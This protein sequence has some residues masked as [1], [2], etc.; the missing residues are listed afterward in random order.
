MSYVT[1]CLLPRR[2]TEATPLVDGDFTV[3]V[4]RTG[5]AGIAKQDQPTA[6]AHW[7]PEERQL[8][9]RTRQQGRT[10]PGSDGQG[11]QPRLTAL[12]RRRLSRRV[13]KPPAWP[14]ASRKAAD[15]PSSGPVLFGAA[16]TREALQRGPRRRGDLGSACG[17]PHRQA[18][19]AVAG[20]Q[21]SEGGGGGQRHFKQA[22]PAAKQLHGFTRSLGKHCLS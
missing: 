2:S 17:N 5:P 16:D 4:R 12:P 3:D 8:Q 15:C 11:S 13:G 21:S 18:A 14:S 7:R 10:A 1:L 6:A 19:C 20:A 9:T 22:A